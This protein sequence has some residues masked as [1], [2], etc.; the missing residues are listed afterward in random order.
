MWRKVVGGYPTA[1]RAVDPVGQAAGCWVLAR[2]HRHSVVLEVDNSTSAAERP[3]LVNLNVSDVVT[4]EWLNQHAPMQ[5][6]DV[7]AT[8]LSGFMPRGI[9][10]YALVGGQPATRVA[11]SVPDCVQL[12]GD[13]F[14]TQWVGDTG[15]C[16]CFAN[17][18]T[19]SVDANPAPRTGVVMTGRRPMGAPIDRRGAACT[20]LAAV[21]PAV[22][23]MEACDGATLSDDGFVLG[24]DL[25]TGAPVCRGFAQMAHVT[26]CCFHSREALRKRERTTVGR[27][28]EHASG[29]VRGWVLSGTSASRGQPCGQR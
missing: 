5:G 23:S 2:W 11:T 18:T 17:D 22:A 15:Q 1:V 26:K 13:A 27:V 3:C 21:S 7:L 9:T 10:S 12:C 8:E 24:V 14:A 20:Q 25:A 19:T 4:T 6:N 29:N 16:T 28:S